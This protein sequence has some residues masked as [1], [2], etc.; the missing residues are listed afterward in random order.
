M[1]NDNE[2]L[3]VL[4]TR[5]RVAGFGRVNLKVEFNSGIEQEY[6]KNLEI[7]VRG[8]KTISLEV[9]ANV[10]VPRVRI[11]EPEIDFGGITCKSTAFHEITIVNDSPIPA[12]LVIN[13]ED[14]PEFDIS[15]S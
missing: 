13:L 1:K 5:A 2:E 3:S 14:H 9:N 12:A 15:L 8:G 7:S 6:K 4:P 11:L 10:I